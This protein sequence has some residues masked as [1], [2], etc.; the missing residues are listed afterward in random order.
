MSPLQFLPIAKAMLGIL[1]CLG[2]L[3]IGK[4]KSHTQV[5][6]KF[7]WQDDYGFSALPSGYYY[8]GFS[9]PGDRSVRWWSSSKYGNSA[10]YT[11]FYA[12]G[13]RFQMN[14]GYGNLYSVRCVKDMKDKGD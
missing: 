9:V 3:S 14:G 4:H 5:A 11:D 12:L 2:K 7:I 8:D 6:A 1:K 13:G 10:I